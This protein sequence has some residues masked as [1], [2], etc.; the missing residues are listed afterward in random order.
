LNDPFHHCKPGIIS[1][2]EAEASLWQHAFAVSDLVQKTLEYRKEYLQHQE[3]SI[4]YVLLQVP[5]PNSVSR[6]DYDTGK[7]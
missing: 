2:F 3:T 6:Y 7:Y 5:S 4:A 1:T